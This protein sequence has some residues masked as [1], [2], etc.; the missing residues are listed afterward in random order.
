MG[1]RTGPSIE[2]I[3]EGELRLLF[4]SH[5]MV[6]PFWIGSIL[7]CR[8]RMDEGELDG[9]NGGVSFRVW[10]VKRKRRMIFTSFCLVGKEVCY[11]LTVTSK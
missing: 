1:I 6:F 11:T 8:C 9:G 3:R 10:L 4:S 5:L 7:V 2:M